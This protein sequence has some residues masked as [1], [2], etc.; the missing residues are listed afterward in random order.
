MRI[1][2]SEYLS[3][4]NSGLY[5]KQS[6]VN[7]I[8]NQ[9]MRISFRNILEQSL[10]TTENTG[11]D[12]VFSKHAQNR[13]QERGIQMTENQLNRLENGTKLAQNKGIKDSLVVVDQLAFI[14]NI[15]NHTVVTAMDQTEAQTNTFTNID[16]AVFV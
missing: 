7:E 9:G 12:V 8:E 6:Q 10:Q 3:T 2:D 5:P 16:G 15:P 13:L 4:V 1:Q 14:V 11:T